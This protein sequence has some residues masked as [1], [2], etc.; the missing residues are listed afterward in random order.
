MINVVYVSLN[1]GLE[2][3]KTRKSGADSLHPHSGLHKPTVKFFLH[4][5]VKQASKH[6]VN[7]VGHKEQQLEHMACFEGRGA[8]QHNGGSAT[9]RCRRKPFR[10]ILSGQF[11]FNYV[12]I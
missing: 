9:A 11:A 6:D 3:R 1:M 4:V 8:A 12:N 2:D 5:D 7:R 10:H